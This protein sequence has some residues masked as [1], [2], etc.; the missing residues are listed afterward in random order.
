MKV[1]FICQDN[2]GRSQV[3]RAYFDQL[4]QHE[5]DSAGMGVDEHVAR[6]NLPSSKIKELTGQRPAEYIRKEFGVD[7]SDQVRKQLTPELVEEADR[8]IVIN[9]R[10]RWPDYVVEGGKVV[11]WD[12]MDA[13]G[14]DDDSLLHIFAQVRK[15]VE[16][17]VQEIG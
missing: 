10:E 14:R 3:A 11:Y 7:I 4:S 15:R 1:L 6:L 17:L 16:E 9:E 2:I 13:Y 5:S 8:V 12:I